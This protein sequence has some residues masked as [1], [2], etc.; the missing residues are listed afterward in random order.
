MDSSAYHA[1][2]NDEISP[3]PQ[4]IFLLNTRLSCT[5]NTVLRLKMLSISPKQTAI[6][7][8]IEL[9][10]GYVVREDHYRYPAGESNVYFLNKEM[11]EE[12]KAELPMEGD[13][14]SNLIS[15]NGEFLSCPSWKGFDCKISLTDG[16]ILDMTF[17]KL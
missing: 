3:S 16:R 14:F 5:I 15:M 12:W 17:S 13:C 2:Y 1:V 10:E 4:G 9:E 11:K 8:V 7:E 6:K